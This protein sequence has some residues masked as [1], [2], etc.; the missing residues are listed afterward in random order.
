MVFFFLFVCCSLVLVVFQRMFLQGTQPAKSI[1][2]CLSAVA[3]LNGS[4]TNAFAIT[5]PRTTVTLAVTSGGSAVT[6]VPTGSIVTL[7]ATVAAGP[8]PVTTGQVN[9]CDASVN[10]CTDVHLLG[11]AQVTSAGTAALMIRPGI[12]THSYKAVFSPNN[13]YIGS[14]SSV[15]TLVVTGTTATLASTT[16]ITE[17]G[18]WG[19]Y[20]LTATVT[21][22][23]GTASPSGAVSFLD[24]SHGNSILDT[25]ALGPSVPGVDWPNPQKLTTERTSQGVALGDFNGDGIPDLAAIAGAP[26]QPLT[27]FLGNANGSYTVAPPTVSPALSY[28]AYSYGPMVVADFNSDGKQ[29]LAILNGDSNTVTILLGNGDGTFNVIASSPAIQ[30]SSTMLP[31]EI[32]MEM[33]SP[34]WQ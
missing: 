28:S 10:N 31:W 16:T 7:T 14:S 11:T 13:G 1:M 24:T 17:A 22:S 5:R 6:S 8:L 3:V 20:A 21:E 23:G 4:W 34:I 30:P 32:S 19:N 18:S 15:S 12:G 26:D 27:I 29:D 9:F 25:V 2:L 33:E